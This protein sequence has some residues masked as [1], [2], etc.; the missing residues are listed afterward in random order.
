MHGHPPKKEIYHI[1]SIPQ[2]LKK[3]VHLMNNFKEYMEEHLLEMADNL[4]DLR[5]ITECT[6]LSKY[7]ATEKA[8]VFRLTNDVIQVSCTDARYD[9]TSN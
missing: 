4:P 9:K 6:Y 2:E 8:V 3:K 1:S 5:F 7:I